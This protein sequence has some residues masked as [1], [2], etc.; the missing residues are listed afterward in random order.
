[1]RSLNSRDL[2]ISLF[3]FLWSAAGSLLG[4]H[5]TLFGI[6]FYRIGSVPPRVCGGSFFLPTFPD[7]TLANR[8]KHRR[9][10]RGYTNYENYL[11]VCI[12][13]MKYIFHIMKLHYFKP[14]MSIMNPYRPPINHVSWHHFNFLEISIGNT[15]SKWNFLFNR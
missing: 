14:H 12:S 6:S 2:L 7:E 15:P 1:M 5:Q 13:P 3:C 8:S 4:C 11:H 10:E 9:Y